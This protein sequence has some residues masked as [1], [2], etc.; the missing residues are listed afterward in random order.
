MAM[1]QRMVHG[2]AF[3]TTRRISKSHGVEC[4]CITDRLI[5]GHG[6]SGVA[7]A[8]QAVWRAGASISALA[9][10]W[11]VALLWTLRDM[12]PTRPAWAGASA[13]FMAGALSALLYSLHASVT[14]GP[15][16]TLGYM[17]GMALMPAIGALLGRWLL[18]W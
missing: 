2:V 7:Q 13:G 5:G 4:G 6:W 9:V 16:E 14:S 11:L 18:R 8:W 1:R 17:L 15:F 12:A 10:P 3:G